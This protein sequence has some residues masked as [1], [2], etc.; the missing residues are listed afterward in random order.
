MVA[1]LKYKCSVTLISLLEARV[2]NEIVSRMMKS[3]HHEIL[4]NNIIDSYYLYDEV[5]KIFQKAIHIVCR[6]EEIWS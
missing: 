6:N 3:L 1:R 2:D 4:K 5:G